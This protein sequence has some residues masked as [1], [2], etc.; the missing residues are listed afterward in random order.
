[1]VSIISEITDYLNRLKAFSRNSKI[2]L[3]SNALTG[4]GVGIFWVILNLYILELGVTP[5]FLGV[6][7]SSHLIASALFLIPGG[8]ISDVIGRKRTLLLSTALLF[9]STI[10]LCTV[11]DRYL[12]I[13]ANSVR[14]VGD[15]LVMVTIVPFMVEQSNN[16]E[17]MHLFSVNAALNSFSIMFGTLVGGL[18]PSTFAFTTQLA[19]QYRFTLLTTSLFVLTA[20]F[21]LLFIKEHTI[22]T[23]PSVYRPFSGKKT[24]VAQFVIY[25]AVVGFGA[26]V[27]VPFFNVYFSRVL[28]APAAHIGVLFSVSQLSVGV[29]SLVLP[30]IVNRFGKVISTVMTQ[31]LSIP[32][33]LI[34]MSHHLVTAF[35]GFFFRMTFMNMSHPAQQHFFMDHLKEHERAKAISISQFGSTLFRA[36]GSNLGGYLIDTKSFSHPFYVAALLYGAATTLFYV[37]FKGKEQ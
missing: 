13:A 6:F 23:P 3:C 37:F 25:S 4:A 1:M 34:M 7:I 22:V 17:R 32:F 36:A 19:E 26:G 29:A 28:N 5:T 24:F 9:L 8:A 35:V 31:A 10:V 2:L 20:F 21:M 30:V 12:L 27:I 11:R 18:L 16:Y 15:A 14:G 33:M